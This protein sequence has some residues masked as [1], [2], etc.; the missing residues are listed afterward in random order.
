MNREEAVLH[1]VRM[2]IIQML[3]KEPRTAQEML[4]EIDAAQATMYRHLRILEKAEI[5]SVEG[6]KQVRGALE[7][8]YVLH[9]EKASFRGGDVAEWSGEDFRKAFLMYHIHLLQLVGDYTSGNIDAEADGFGF[10]QVELFLDEED[11]KEFQQEYVQLL[12]KYEAK[13]DTAARRRTLAA[14]FIPEKKQG[15]DL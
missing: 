9:A 13:R 5:I 3:M 10:H 6:E 15:R 1:P 4:K 7:K 2:K 8:T 12:Q 14:A 11:F